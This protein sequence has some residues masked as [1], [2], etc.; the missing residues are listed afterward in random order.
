M[1]ENKN[2]DTNGYFSSLPRYYCG[3]TKTIKSIN[4]VSTSHC[5]RELNLLKLEMDTALRK[6]N[7]VLWTILAKEYN[8]INW[9]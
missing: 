9:Q 1:N 2:N 4:D 5:E 6:N 8:R 3:S 7:K